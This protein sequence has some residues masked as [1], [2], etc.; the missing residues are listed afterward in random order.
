MLFKLSNFGPDG[1]APSRMVGVCLCSSS[2]T[3]ESPE[4]FLL[5]PAHPGGPGKRA[6]KWWLLV[7]V[8][9]VSLIVYRYRAIQWCQLLLSIRY[10]VGFSYSFGYINEK[11]FG[12][13][14]R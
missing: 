1:V 12:F 3:P 5:A 14:Q 10:C 2:L 13:H 11:P 4:V 6:V 7:V 8:S 9:Y